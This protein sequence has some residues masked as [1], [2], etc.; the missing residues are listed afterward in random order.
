[1]A[2]TSGLGSLTTSGGSPRLSGTS[3]K[4]DTETLVAAAYAAKRAPAVRLE[5]KIEGNAAK[6]TAY[7]ELRG[8]LE[9]LRAA[10]AGL[11][12]PPGALGA[13][14]NLFEAKEAYLSS[15]T[16]AAPTALVGVDVDPAAAVGS[17]SLVVD[18]LATAEKQASASAAGPGTTLADAWNGGSAFAG[19]LLVGL[20]GGATQR[21][22]VDGAMTLRELRDAINAVAGASGVTASVLKI[23]DGD[24][25]LV[26][27]GK[28]TGRAVVLASDPAG[29]DVVAKM[30]MAQI[31]PAR[32]SRILVDGVAVERATNTVTDL[33]DGL[34]ISLFKADPATTV[35]VGVEPSL[36]AIKDGIKGFVDAYDGVRAFLERSSAVDD[37]GKAKEGAV[38][39]GDRFLR[40][41]TDS[42]AGLAGRSVPG[43]GAPGA[44]T[45]LGDLGIR[46]DAGNR[47][48][49]DEATLDRR[50]LAD[51][52]GVRGVLEF[53]FSAA[54]PELRA[55]G[56][57]N[58]LG[59]A[60][61][62][63]AVV[64]ADADGVPE[65]ASFDGVPAELAGGRILG[66][67]G[68]AYDG[69][70]LGW[71]GRGSA[72]IAVETRPGI[73]DQL[74]NALD[75][76]LD[77]QGPL[78]RA[79]D[80]L[81]ERDRSYRTEIED[82]DRRAEAARARLVERFA[83]MEAALSAADAMMQQVKAQ[84]DA[85]SSGN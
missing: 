79:V 50:L 14:E 54:S 29:D 28:E 23:A 35:A 51:P 44:P 47:L 61:F 57:T 82:I 70:A 32:T 13:K 49:L 75:E 65:S 20:A 31:Q 81:G 2:T 1:M 45:T 36:A 5:R 60:S 40:A 17:F 4:I 24:H 56:R 53:G 80:T 10:L 42:L 7:G 73:A 33:Y 59:D 71:V 63:V 34:A 85:M 3:S 77:P 21:V 52:A 37:T 6:A 69:L 83:A 30:G 55:L 8:L 15:S 16:A 72:S 66:A 26:L 41:I 62:T 76:A 64:D 18:R 11:R 12:N 46:F 58:R 39:A 38:L 48:V 27:T 67:K 22:A 68:S 9:R 19:G 25:R 84:M 74:F 43:S 78:Q